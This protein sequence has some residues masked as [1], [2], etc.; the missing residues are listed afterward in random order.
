VSPKTVR[1]DLVRWD[2][3]FADLEAQASALD[4]AERAAEIAERTR[5]E[6]GGLGVHDRLA[7][8]VGAS[9]RVEALG[10]EARAGTIA[11]VGAD[12]V[13]LDEGAGRESVI[14]IDAIRSV[15]GLGRASAVPGSGGAVHA[16][17]VLRTALRGVARD[18]STVRLHLR[19]G[20]A[21]D[22]TLDRVGADFVEVAR[23]AP[24]EPRRR[25]EVR[26]V[27]LLPL[28]ALAIVSRRVG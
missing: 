20:A 11:R 1:F 5:I 21:L 23:H 26:D 8:G 17:L 28:A 15:A 19:D 24:G 25:G 14:A 10:G 3:L 27:L 2:E 4:V 13:L 18:R 9:V 16:R 12:W 6:V 7:A 22:A